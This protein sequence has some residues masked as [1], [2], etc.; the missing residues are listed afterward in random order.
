MTY[1]IICMDNKDKVDGNS[2]MKE[3]YD[4]C[5]SSYGC[6]GYG[7]DLI[8]PEGEKIEIY[9]CGKDGFENR[10]LDSFVE[11]YQKGK[12]IPSFRVGY[13]S[14]DEM[15][16]TLPS[17][18]YEF[19]SEIMDLTENLG[20]TYQF[21]QVEACVNAVKEGFPV[22]LKLDERQTDKEILLSQV[23]DEEIL[24]ATFTDRFMSRG[25]FDALE[26]YVPAIV[27]FETDGY[28]VS[29]VVAVDK[30]GQEQNFKLKEPVIISD[31]DFDFVSEKEIPATIKEMTL[32]HY[33]IPSEKAVS[34]LDLDEMDKTAQKFNELAKE[35]ENF[36]NALDKLGMI[37]KYSENSFGETVIQAR[38]PK[39]NPDVDTYW[40]LDKNRYKSGEEIIIMSDAIK[41]LPLHEKNPAKIIDAIEK[42][43]EKYKNFQKEYRKDGV[44]IDKKQL[45]KEY[46]NQKNKEKENFLSR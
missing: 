24:R 20:E 8:L 13:V 28:S 16:E 7:Y 44:K 31:Y 45:E 4:Y 36:S 17:N 9:G 34:E 43:I 15:I 11:D 37:L 25:G 10:T 2:T 46:S 5:N 3:I 32:S 26:I 30:T 42:T 41:R 27:K 33:A 19:A 21:A 35:S 29:E 22:C 12:E 40:T 6:G 39:S 23:P 14:Y 18:E 1:D 38:F